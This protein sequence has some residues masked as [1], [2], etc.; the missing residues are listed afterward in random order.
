VAELGS[1]PDGELPVS[2]K[3]DLMQWYVDINET[4]VRTIEHRSHL[5][6]A[7]A[8]EL[9]GLCAILIHGDI[10]VDAIEAWLKGNSGIRKN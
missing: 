6:T 7:E 2:K 4:W 1:L 9:C 5:R 3:G 8:C 10:L